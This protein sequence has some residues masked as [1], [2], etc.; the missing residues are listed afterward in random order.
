[1]E[2]MEPPTPAVRVTNNHCPNSI[3]G[4]IVRTAYIT[5]MLSI[6]AERKPTILE[7]LK[8]K[9]KGYYLATVHR[10][11]NTDDKYRLKNI[12]EALI[13]ISKNKPV[14]LPIHPRTRKN[15]KF[16]KL[17]SLD[18]NQVNLIDPISYFDMIIL[19]KNADKIL[20][21][22]GGLQKEAYILKVPCIT[23][24]EET[25]WVETVKDGL[26]VLVGS[27]KQKIIDIT[28]EFKLKSHFRNYFGDGNTSTKILEILTDV[29]KSIQV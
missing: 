21:D 4:I 19:E 6:I 8:L 2:S 24:R 1:M 29:Y 7:K 11:E 13:K 3:S 26:N 9:E 20:T 23:L 18:F 17:S 28:Q 25:E 10:A 14:V 27:N 16:F 5:G 12:I 15:L 22:S